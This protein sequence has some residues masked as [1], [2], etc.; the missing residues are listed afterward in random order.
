VILVAPECR[1]RAE[2]ARLYH[3]TW[4]LWNLYKDGWM[5]MIVQKP[6]IKFPELFCIPSD[7]E[8]CIVDFFGRW[9]DQ[10]KLW[11]ARFFWCLHITE[12]WVHHSFLGSP[13]E[14]G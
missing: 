1:D 8:N 3:G 4:L 7:R 12:S 9:I 2:Y 14:S 6:G 5:C 10:G 13:N 11:A